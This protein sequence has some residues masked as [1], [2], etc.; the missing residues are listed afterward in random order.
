MQ[1]IGTM[2]TQN[3]FTYFLDI[4][5]IYTCEKEILEH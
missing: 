3:I 5:L 4:E 2:I 1:I